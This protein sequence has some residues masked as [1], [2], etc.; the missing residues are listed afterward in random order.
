MKSPLFLSLAILFIL[1][2]CSSREQEAEIS[3]VSLPLKET[4]TVNDLE[5]YISELDII[6]MSTDTVSLLGISK[7]LV[8]SEDNFFILAGGIPYIVSKTGDH[9]TRIGAIGRGSGEYI[10]VKDIAI[11][12]ERTE[13]WCLDYRN[14]LLRYDSGSGLF[15]GYTDLGL[16]YGQSDAIIPMSDGLFAA[17]FPNPYTKDLEKGNV[18]FNCLKLFNMDGKLKNET[19]PWDDYNIDAAFSIPV[20]CSDDFVYVLSPGLFYPSIVFENGKEK[21]RILVDFEKKNVPYRFMFQEGKVPM[22]MLGEL[23][24]RDYYK[25]ISSF[26][27][28]NGN[29]FFRAFGKNSSLWNFFIPESGSTGIRWE[30]I[31]ITMPPVSAVGADSGYLFFPFDDY[32]EIEAKEEQDPLKKIVLGRFGLPFEPAPC[33]IK[34]KFNV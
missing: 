19:M 2:S 25:L 21:E 4:K 20:S 9:F 31:G 27:Y 17:Y 14:I 13:L 11:N 3:R 7:V 18:S 16:D 1:P 33:L 5:S 29:V 30:S 24:E 8:L 15:M 34:V 28:S 26:F 10:T 23:F 6:P 12:L 32:G 22:H